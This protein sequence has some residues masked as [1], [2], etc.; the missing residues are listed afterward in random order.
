MQPPITIAAPIR[1]A[2]SGTFPP[3]VGVQVSVPAIAPGRSPI[4]IGT[5]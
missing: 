5:L 2:G 3:G 1:I 4:R